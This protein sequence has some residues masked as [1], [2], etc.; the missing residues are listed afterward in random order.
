MINKLKAITFSYDDGVTQDIR[1]IELFDKYGVKCTFNLNSELLGQD[2]SLLREGK[3]VGHNK[4]KNS[5]VIDIYK[6]HEVAVHTLTHPNLTTLTENEIIHQVETDRLNLSDLVGYEVVGMA[7]P[8]GGVNNDD[9]VAAVIK[10]HTGV[11]YARTITSS[12]SFD[13][14][15][16]LFRFNPTVYH[17][18]DGFKMLNDMF[19]KFINTHTDEMQTLYIW[20]HSYEFDIH[21]DWDKME[22]FLKKISFRDDIFYGTNTEVLLRSY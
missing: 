2:G 16:N 19:D 8:C 9:R 21:D 17:H 4:V 15:E 6:N 22:E 12:Y 3:T 14:Q 20:G 7:Y 1:L 5:D 11:R 18:G 10:N 13:K